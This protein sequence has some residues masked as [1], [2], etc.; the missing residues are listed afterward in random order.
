MTAPK[1]KYT[2]VG[3]AERILTEG[4]TRCDLCKY[5]ESNYERETLTREMRDAFTDKCKHC[6]Q[7]VRLYY[8]ADWKKKHVWAEDQFKPLYRVDEGED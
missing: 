3:Y 5:E 6:I 2:F 4:L 1:K 7:R 8:G